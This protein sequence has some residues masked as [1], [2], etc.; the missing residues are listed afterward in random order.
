MKRMIPILFSILLIISCK[1]EKQ[2]STF[3]DPNLIAQVGDIIPDVELD[4][5][6]QNCNTGGL[7]PQ[8]YAYKEKPFAKGKLHLRKSRQRQ[9]NLSP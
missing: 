2:T 9:D 4:G 6:F 1:E 3:A 7:L 5:D 8:Y